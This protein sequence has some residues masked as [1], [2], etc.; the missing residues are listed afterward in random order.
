VHQDTVKNSHSL[1]TSQEMT[2]SAWDGFVVTSACSGARRV[3]IGGEGALPGLRF[4]YRAGDFLLPSF[5]DRG[6]VVADIPDFNRE[7]V[8]ALP[9]G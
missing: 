6:R 2:L 3:T 1:S 5:S 9:E 7:L 8:A 4:T